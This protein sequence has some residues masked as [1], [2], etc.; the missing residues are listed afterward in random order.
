M[1]F[2][3]T[4]KRASFIS[5][6][7]VLVLFFV[8]FF[9]VSNFA[10]S[11]FDLNL[12]AMSKQEIQEDSIIKNFTITQLPAIPSQPIKWIKT[13]K[14]DALNKGEYL[15]ELPK[16]ADHIKI[17]PIKPIL[18]KT[19]KLTNKDRIKLAQEAK[20]R[21]NSK[22]SLALERS[23]KN[24]SNIFSFLLASV[25]D[26]M[27]SLIDAQPETTVPEVILLD[28]TTEVSVPEEVAPVSNEETISIP[29]VPETV[30]EVPV[31]S[32]ETTVV[33]VDSDSTNSSQIEEVVP[34]AEIIPEV[35]T[36]IEVLQE[37]VVENTSEIP[38]SEE[39]ASIAPLSEVDLDVTAV[40]EVPDIQ[41]TYETPA[42]IIA[43]A[44][45]NTGKIVQIS[46]PDTVTNPNTGTVTKQHITNVLAFTNIPEIYK[47]GQ[48]SKIK[49]KWQN[50][51]DKN[52]K[53][54]AY[55]LNG[56]GK[57]DYV[58]WTV[59]HLSTQTF[60]IIFISKAFLL[61][62]NKDILEDIYDTVKEQD[63]NYITIP[64]D[65]YVR[66]TFYKT[67]NRTKDITLYAKPNDL[68]VPVSIQ[69]YPVYVDV[70]D[71]QT[72]GPQLTLVSDNQNPDFSNISQDGKY[73]VLLSN[74]QNST[75]VFDL[76]I[77]G[78]SIDVD[79]IVDPIET[80]QTAHWKF[81]ENEIAGTSVA[82]S[83]GSFTGTLVGTVM[84]DTNGLSTPGKLNGA[85]SFVGGSGDYIDIPDLGDSLQLGS[86]KSLVFWIN[87][88]DNGDRPNYFTKLGTGGGIQPANGWYFKTNVNDVVLGG[89][90]DA[91]YTLDTSGSLMDGAWHLV[92][93]SIDASN[94]YYY[95]DNSLISTTGYTS[96]PSGGAGANFQIGFTSEAGPA[97]WVG[98]L[99][100]I[101]FYNKTM[102]AT[103]VSD[104]WNGGTGTEADS[105]NVAPNVPTLVSPANASLVADNTPTLSANYSDSDTGDVGTT[106]YRISSG[107]AQNCLDNA[108][109]TASGTSAETADENEDTTW[110]PS[111]TIGNDGTYY[112]CA[113]NNDGVA[114]SAWTSM[115]SFTLAHVWGGASSTAWS[116]AANWQGGEVPDAG[117]DV[118][119]NGT[120]N[121]ASSIDDSFAGSVGSISINSGYT[122]I[123]TN[124]RTSG[125][126][127]VTTS[128]KTGTFTIASGTY[129]ANGKT[130]SV[131]GDWTNN[132]GTFTSGTGTVTF[133]GSGAQSINGT[134]SS[135]T[136][137]N[138]TTSST[139]ALT[140]GGS[141]TTLTLNG[142]L[143][144]GSGTSFDV[145]TATTVN[146][147][148]DWTNNGGTFTPGT[149]KTVTFNGSGAQSINGT[150]ASQT[151]YWMTLSSTSALTVGGSTTTLNI[152][153]LTLGSGTSLDAGTATAINISGDWTNNGGTF[154][155]GTGT[156]TF[157]STL[158]RTIG[159]TAASQTFYNLIVN[160]TSGKTLTVGGSTT[161]LTTQNFT[162]TT[163]NFTAPATLNINGNATLTAGTFTAGT[164]TNVTGNWANNGSTFTAGTGTVTLNG[165]SQIISGSST[166]YNLTKSVSSADTLTFT[167]GT[168]Q[169]IS[170]TL[171][172]NGASG[173]LLSLR[174]SSTPTQWNIN[175]QSTR[176]L[177]Y[178]DVK[179]SN[180][181]NAT[182]IDTTGLNIT[183]SLNNTNWTFN[184]TPNVPTLVSPANASYTTDNTPTLSANYSD[185][186]TGDVGTTNYRI[187]SGTA[188]NCLDNAN[189]ASSGASSETADE[190]ED[191]TFTPG[192]TIGSD[193]TYYWCA[194][195]NDGVATSAWT[196]MGNFVL[197]TTNPVPTITSPTD[198]ASYNN[199]SVSISSS[200]S[201]TNLGSLVS[202]L[203]SGL[204]SWWRMDDVDGSGN[205][206][207]YMGTNNGTK[208]GDAV[209]TSSGKFGKAFTFDGTGD[210]ILANDISL[211]SNAVS[212]CAWI[213][214]AA[215][216]T[217]NSNNVVLEKWDSGVGKRIF[218]LWQ[219]INTNTIGFA[220]SNSGSYQAGNLLTTT[221]S[222]Y[223]GS[224]HHICGIHD[225]SYNYL[226]VDGSLDK[227]V[228][229]ANGLYN[230]SLSTSIGCTMVSGACQGNDYFNGLIDEAMIFTRALTSDE[231]RALYDGTAVSHSSTLAEGSHTYKAYASDLAG[232]VIASSLNTFSIDTTAPADPSATPA[233]G[234]YDSA[235]SVSLSSS[236]SSAIYYTTNGDTPTSSSTLYV[237]PISISTATTLKAIA[238]DLAT[239]Q[240]GVVTESYVFDVTAPT[241]SAT[242]TNTAGSYTFGNW[243]VSNVS[244]TLSCTDNVGGVGCDTPTYPKYCVDQANT[245][246]PT[247][248]YTTSVS[249]STEGTNYIRYYSA[250][251]IPNTETTKSSIIKID[252]ST[253]VISNIS[254]SSGSNLATDQ[255]ITFTTDETA[256]C[257]LAL[258]D[259]AK[260][261]DEMSSDV[262]CSVSNGIQMSCVPPT[263]GSA[264]TKNMYLACKDSYDNKDTAISSTHVD[265]IYARGGHAVSGGGGGSPAPS[266]GTF[267]VSVNNGTSSTN[268]R[269]VTLDFNSSGTGATA[270]IL[271]NNPDFSGGVIIPYQANT[272]F[273]LCG[274]NT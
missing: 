12:E 23:L 234:T 27:D 100:D 138:I 55:D 91:E 31:V 35:S 237:A 19:S 209:Q 108:N 231:V 1:D 190:N 255:A 116:T 21:I 65:N 269:V 212:A 188:Q 126:A 271:A 74:L 117:D 8:V 149:S 226:Y 163:G 125:L 73:R 69:V 88:T 246:S 252:K 75:D 46:A 105:S 257:R 42:P 81:N 14:A 142:S 143:T 54:H 38:T 122:N 186:D 238:Y 179:D 187:S 148:G 250:D 264:G 171:T 121:T 152:R 194:Q 192:S 129:D 242:A 6:L 196:S 217:V 248:S 156:V 178:L 109:I 184:A 164:N 162:E 176:T 39:T 260:S 52:V 208:Y 89:L 169:I 201:D 195:N 170:N 114:T 220:T 141:T 26:A 3:D 232:N 104:V 153:T 267:D 258:S 24:K 247:T 204:V 272:Q 34:V 59:P 236:G 270:V 107:T 7:G 28:V 225:G 151:F 67:L 80:G 198:S 254:P 245:C 87:T 10:T 115:G 62:S 79:Y 119:F 66:A 259:T 84:T 111:S 71:N 2:F 241:T 18:Q 240:S 159:G 146:V 243:S 140:V 78:G 266:I 150:A 43:E 92:V 103:D 185:S 251:T 64:Q 77:I 239:N 57:L 15:L 233:G 263:L 136:F 85:F 102:D 155:P 172:L 214:I 223:D 173:Q 93:I 106:N 213:N 131:A 206:T 70:D 160:L 5:D 265:Y 139:S 48:E 11:F 120:G 193:G 157:D 228:D 76:K 90:D 219:T 94:I 167:A 147:A 72:E 134:A 174:S 161:S 181:T 199:T 224:W 22:E 110:T 135:Q 182:A 33:L 261:Y 203:D 205:P 229:A 53:F 227:S 40:S 216:N 222:M 177:S 200:A 30:P 37:D 130:T 16:T 9:Y 113:Q 97:A 137:K 144:L 244:V 51:N 118:V 207:D 127:V 256:E 36:D 86:G 49:I 215:S 13:I 273:D 133:N 60:E 123:I 68:S 249:I 98:T 197:D 32:E 61:D 45:T 268:N 99:D 58:E 145:G 29:A 50:N 41:V 112:W 83:V 17:T 202:N 132:G 4:Q 44:D 210:Y 25:G 168:T 56:N 158:D 183:N 230:S 235:Q 63:K 154:T 189:I 180:N 47:V 191:T 124:N 96:A 274:N 175:P 128:G 20:T 211:T 166:F 221:L 253:P 101:R 165:T 218:A 95:V 262:S 82:D